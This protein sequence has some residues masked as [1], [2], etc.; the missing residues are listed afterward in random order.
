M[1]DYSSH[2]S[3]SGFGVDEYALPSGSKIDQVHMIH[4]HGGRYPAV[5]STIEKFGK[6][7][8]EAIENGAKF[9]GELSFLNGWSYGLG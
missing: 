5:N 4:R 8:S 7:L 2:F 6:A 1:R 3:H 9:S